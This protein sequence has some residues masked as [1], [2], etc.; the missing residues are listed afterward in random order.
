MKYQ[1]GF[2]DDFEHFTVA[3]SDEVEEDKVDK[4][5]E[6]EVVAGEKSVTW[7]VRHTTHIPPS[8]APEEPVRP[9]SPINRSSNPTEDKI[10]KEIREMKEREEELKLVRETVVNGVVN[11]KDE[12]PN[13]EN[14]ARCVY[15]TAY[16][17]SSAKKIVFT[18]KSFNMRDKQR[19]SLYSIGVGFFS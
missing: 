4:V 1:F 5:V 16:G 17:C 15:C 11:G 12:K 19:Y 10:A 7:G 3:D 18:S 9:S 14:K 8:H 2:S 13:I 6:K